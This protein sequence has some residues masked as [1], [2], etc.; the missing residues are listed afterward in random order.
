[1]DLPEVVEVQRLALQPGDRLVV[2]TNWPE[3]S[4]QQAY[5]I[6]R[7]IGKVVGGNVPVLILP[8]DWSVEVVSEEDIPVEER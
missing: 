3:L 2:R 1:M 4:Q 7:E 5:E 6:R 8:R